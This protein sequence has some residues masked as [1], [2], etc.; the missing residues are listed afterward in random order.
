[1]DEEAGKAGSNFVSESDIKAV[2]TQCVFTTHTPVPAGHDKFFFELFRK[3]FQDRQDFLDMKDCL[4]VKSA[5]HNNEIGPESK[6]IIS[7]K[8]LLTLCFAR[9]MTSY[10]RADLIFNDIERLKNISGNAGPLQLVFAGKAHPRDQEG[11]EIIK[12]ILDIKEKLK[13]EIKISYL[14]NYDMRHAIALN[15]SFFNTQRMLQQYVTNAYFL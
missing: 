15:G 12:R 5:D 4:C 11:K 1:L 8:D 2:K 10:K 13:N 3:V 6:Q 7:D 14:P 9:R